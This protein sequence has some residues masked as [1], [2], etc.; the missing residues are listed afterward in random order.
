MKLNEIIDLSNEQ[1]NVE[2]LK[3]VA[4]RQADQAKAAQARLS[5]RKSQ[6]RLSKLR[7]TSTAP[8]LSTQ[9]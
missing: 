2:R 5:I 9:H 4:K 7:Q 3:Q 8:E 6:E 1:R